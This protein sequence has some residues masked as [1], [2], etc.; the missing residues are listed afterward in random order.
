MIAHITGVDAA[1]FFALASLP[2]AL[3][4]L[5]NRWLD[6]PQREDTKRWKQISRVANE[7]ADEME[8]L[9]ARDRHP[10]GKNFVK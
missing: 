3:S 6:S 7:V 8:Y 1:A 5:F 10:A 4:I 2:W 9:R